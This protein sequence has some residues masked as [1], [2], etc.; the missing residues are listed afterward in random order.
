L[1]LFSVSPTE[2]K[3]KGILAQVRWS[4]QNRRQ[5]WTS[6]QNRTSRMQLQND[7]SAGNG[8]YAQ[9]GTT[10]RVMAASRPKVTFW[11]DSGTSTGNY[12]YEWY[13]VCYIA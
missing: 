6:S 1:L 8:A 11:P 9:K 4:R 5:C 7:R 2:D 10:L 3:L 12:G 13:I